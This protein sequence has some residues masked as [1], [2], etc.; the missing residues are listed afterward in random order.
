MRRRYRKRPDSFVT[1]V[2]LDL[3]TEGFTF[4]K[5]GGPQTCKA[6]DWIVDNDG[7]VY[8]VDADT[9]DRTYEMRSPGVYVKTTT[10]WAEVAE[11]KG[12]VKTLE[13]STAY[14]VGDY[15]VFNQEDGSDAYAM[16]AESFERMYEPLDA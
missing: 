2:R 7:D 3:D 4:Q 5:W 8:S 14:E 9:F 11:A 12:V 13:G 15:L 10:V 16:S 1:A 6:G